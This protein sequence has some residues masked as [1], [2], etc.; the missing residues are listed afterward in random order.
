MLRAQNICFHGEV[1]K[2]IYLL[3]P[4]SRLQS[5]HSAYQIRFCNSST[6][7]YQQ[8]EPPAL[9]LMVVSLW[10]PLNNLDMHYG[11]GKLQIYPSGFHS[12]AGL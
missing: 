12:A 10:D 11:F 6:S 5:T 8:Q 1:K 3:P 2:N 4:L 7:T 9:S